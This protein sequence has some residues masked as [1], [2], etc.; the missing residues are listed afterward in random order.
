MK[1]LRDLLVIE[2]NQQPAEEQTSSGLYL[3]KPRWAK[4]QNMARVLHKG[5]EVKS[6]GEGDTI[7]INPYA[8]QDTDDEN[9]KIIKEK[10][11]LCLMS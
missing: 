7:L 9:V 4:P 3:A 6:V 2:I 5:P 8:Y 10:D 11:V 1:P